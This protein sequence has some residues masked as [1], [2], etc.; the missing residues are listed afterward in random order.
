MVPQTLRKYTATF[1]S[2][3]VHLRICVWLHLSVATLV[4]RVCNVYGVACP[5]YFDYVGS[6]G[7]VKFCV[8]GIGGWRQLHHPTIGILHFLHVG[9]L[10]GGDLFLLF[11]AEG[12]GANDDLEVFF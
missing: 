2:R 9:A 6:V 3:V 4:L 5:I 1:I 12:P 8:E 11:L 7:V 10:I